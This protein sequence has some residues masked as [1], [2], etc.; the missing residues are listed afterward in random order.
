MRQVVLGDASIAHVLPEMGML[1]LFG[2]IGLP[3]SVLAF[4][5]AVRWARVAG[6]LGHF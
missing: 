1:A 6:T 2:L 4:C 5:W 3:V